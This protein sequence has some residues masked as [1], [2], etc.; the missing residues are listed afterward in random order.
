M[1]KYIIIIVVYLLA[2]NLISFALFGLD[3]YKA[4]KHRFRISERRLFLSALLGGSLGALLGMTHFHHKTKHRIFQIGIPLIL[5]CQL[6]VIGWLV[7]N[8]I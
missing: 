2:I 6:A 4:R 1:E 3:K 7:C 5:I 8:A